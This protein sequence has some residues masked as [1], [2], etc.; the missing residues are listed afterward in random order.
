MLRSKSREMGLGSLTKVTLADARRKAADARL[1]LSD[2][3]DPLLLRREE[4]A[5]RAAEEKV[6][7]NSAVTFEKSK[8]RRNGAMAVMRSVLDL[9][10]IQPIQ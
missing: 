9:D 1:A 7:A 3:R 6:A 4:K 2:G 8:S 10:R 5:Q